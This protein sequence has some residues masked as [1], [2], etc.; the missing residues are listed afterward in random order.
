[1]ALSGLA[2]VLARLPGGRDNDHPYTR[3]PEPSGNRY[4][5]ATNSPHLRRLLCGALGLLL[6]T[7]PASA[8]SN[9]TP[10][11]RL[12]VLVLDVSGSFRPWLPQARA[13]AQQV[14]RQLA[15]GD[16]LLAR[17]LGSESFGEVPALALRLPARTRPIDPAFD[18]RVLALTQRAAA[19][20][21][22][23]LQ[24]PVARQTD[25]WGAL[26][27][28][29]DTLA[30]TPA[31]ERWL[32]LYTDLDDTVGRAVAARPLRLAGVRVR[33]L[34]VPRSA[35]VRQFDARLRAWRDVFGGGSAEQVQFYDTS[36]FPLEVSR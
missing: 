29:A 34:F 6:A 14:I 31:R 36:L 2:R 7:V 8:G 33:V 22:D 16:C 18:R 20:L 10:C 1:M 17:P 15:A 26:Y 4:R 23:M 32:L 27:A 3:R 35:D 5:H 21:A 24:R 25:V 12:V 11:R 9:D 19:D 30:A 28:A 13:H